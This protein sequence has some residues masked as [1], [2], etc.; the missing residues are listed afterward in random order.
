[1]KSQL[2]SNQ[3]IAISP[4]LKPLSFTAEVVSRR[5]SPLSF[6][7]LLFTFL[8]AQN[9]FAQYTYSTPGTYL[10]DDNG[11]N[12]PMVYGD[13]I[14]V[15]AGVT[16]IIENR[17]AGLNLV[18]NN[19]KGITVDAGAH[20]IVRN[21]IL[22][23]D[24]SYQW[25]GIY[26][27]GSG[28]G[29]EQYLL[30]PKI[31]AAPLGTSNVSEWEGVINNT[32]M[33]WV[34]FYASTI[35]NA[36]D[37]I[38]SV[39]G[40][41]IW[42]D[43]KNS[44]EDATF[45][46]CRNGVLIE[47]YLSDQC[48]NVNACHIMQADFLWDTYNTVIGLG[49]R[50]QLTGI[51]L[52]SVRGV[53]IG[54]CN[55]KNT[56]SGQFC[57]TD[58]ATGIRSLS[59]DFTLSKSGNAFS[60]DEQGCLDN[61]YFNLTPPPTSRGNTFEQ[62]STGIEIKLDAGNGNSYRSFNSIRHSTFTNNF[63]SVVSE[64]SNSLIVNKCSFTG[65]R[66]VLN[67]LFGLYVYGQNNTLSCELGYISTSLY[68]DIH[69]SGTCGVRILDNTFDFD[70]RNVHHIEVFGS[71]ISP[72]Y[73]SFIKKNTFTNSYLSPG[74]VHAINSDN[75]KA[76]VLDGVCTNLDVTCNTF[77]EFGNDIFIGTSGVVS[78]FK[79]VGLV[80]Y[81]PSNILSSGLSGR[82]Q[83]YSESTVMSPY[84]VYK[85][86][87]GGVYSPPASA[88]W[89]TPSS[90]FIDEIG[91]DYTCTDLLD[92]LPDPAP[93]T[94]GTVAKIRTIPSNA[95]KI[96]PNPTSGDIYLD[97]VFRGADMNYSIQVLSLDGKVVKEIAIKN[98]GNNNSINFH[99][100][101]TGLYLVKVA[102][103]NH[104]LSGRVLLK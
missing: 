22:E 68:V 90:D 57:L 50:K 54:G 29:D 77:N 55:F 104:N 64:N 99:E 74:S 66:S 14:T 58:R 52:Q 65:E 86:K 84:P 39:N 88:R 67:S 87:I 63:S 20:L 31:P 26:V 48:P 92:G 6:C 35:D 80:Y 75:V 45:L 96:Y 69:T 34:E 61:F 81:S 10:I 32:D 102:T 53:N 78:D 17:E 5:N 28:N 91:C 44:N 93:C 83:I 3:G 71:D 25:S 8:S 23:T 42:V 49:L 11:N 70:K 16:L 79:K 46:N 9:L 97:I 89:V 33:G 101:N 95:L 38:R 47:P 37:G 27:N 85:S 36:S 60:Y 73:S 98:L 76:I 82:D 103:A 41:V 24:T 62:L 40:G 30:A 7:F 43:G 100:L 2:L 19:N 56:I 1:M 4:Y 72:N 94:L 12:P 51:L 21:S 13:G 59:S 18:F 15:E